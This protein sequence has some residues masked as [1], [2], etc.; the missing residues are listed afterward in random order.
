MKSLWF[1]SIFSWLV[2]GSAWAEE[3]VN[4]AVKTEAS[5]HFRQGGELFREG[6]YRAALV[7]LQRAH[8]LL[9]DYRVLFNIG[10]TQLQLGEY[11][12][13]IR[14]FEAY[15]VQ[16][17]SAVDPQRRQETEK[18]LIMLRKRV[19]TLSISVNVEGADVIV[20]STHVGKSPLSGTIPVSVGRHRV[21]AQGKDGTTSSVVVEVAGGDLQEVA[22]ELTPTASL[23]EPAPVDSGARSEETTGLSKRKK[24]A[25]G[26]LSAGAVVGIGAGVAGLFAKGA[27]DKY[28]DRLAELPGSKSEISS[29]RDDMQLRGY[30]TD[31]LAIAA[32]GLGVTSVVLFVVGDETAPGAAKVELSVLPSGLMARGEF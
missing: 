8:A 25:L 15:L 14:A 28:Q 29:A 20:D 23:V 2:A 24:W 32:V 21:F 11:V 17:G 30:L 27:R 26:L 13:A 4:D 7:E 12:E 19:A 18:D 9:P 10:Q 22:L 31:G 16:G 5:S 6:A 3:P 1:L